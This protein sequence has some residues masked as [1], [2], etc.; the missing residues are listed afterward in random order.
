MEEIAKSKQSR[1]ILR[2]PSLRG[3]LTRSRT[4]SR[5]P[6]EERPTKKKEEFLHE[7]VT[8]TKTKAEAPPVS[9]TVPSSGRS[10]F[11]RGRQGNTT[12]S[13]SSRAEVSSPQLLNTTTDQVGSALEIAGSTRTISP[14]PRGPQRTSMIPAPVQTV[15]TVEVYHRETTQPVSVEPVPRNAPVYGRLS[16][17][18]SVTKP[19]TRVQVFTA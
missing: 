6:S 10:N 1:G 11:F 16:E 15:N 5:G 7:S 17:A 13:S 3:T 8:Y 2:V 4:P 14:S 9:S 18:R 12:T 19:S